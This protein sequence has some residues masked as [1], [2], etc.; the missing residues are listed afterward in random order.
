MKRRLAI[1]LG[2][3][4]LAV[5]LATL[6]LWT[7]G[8]SKGWQWR[9]RTRTF[10]IGAG[11]LQLDLYGGGIEPYWWGPNPPPRQLVGPPPLMWRSVSGGSWGGFAWREF[12]VVDMLMSIGPPPGVTFTL[13]RWQAPFW[14]L[15]V[16]ETGLLALWWLWLGSV[17]RA[18]RWAREGRCLRCGY[19]LRA[20]PE[21]CPECGTAAVP[22]RAV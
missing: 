15:G 6:T 11:V 8:Y 14:C 22:G 17:R 16:L 21:R 20:S 2:F 13:T 5:F 4:L 18:H 9:G 7:V 19:D 10:K 1:F 3:V 12:H